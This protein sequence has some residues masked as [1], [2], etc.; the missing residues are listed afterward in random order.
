M[1][2]VRVSII[3]CEITL[4][5]NYAEKFNLY[6]FNVEYDTLVNAYQNVTRFSSDTNKR[7]LSLCD[8]ERTKEKVNWQR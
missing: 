7:I 3:L 1:I 4:E 2:S 6:V 5:F 8:S